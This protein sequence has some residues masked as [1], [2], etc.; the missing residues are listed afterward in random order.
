MT[1]TFFRTAI[2]A[3]TVGLV[4]QPGAQPEET[5]QIGPTAHA[6]LPANASELWLVPTGSS[7]EA[8]TTPTYRPLVDGVAK[9]QA[10][11]YAAALPLLTNPSLA[12]TPLYPYALYYT[13]LAQLRLDRVNDARRTLES[14][15]ERAP[16]GYV[17]VAATLAAGEAAS[18][19]GDH[20]EALRLY[21]RL[22]GEKAAVNDE[23]LTR[24]GRAAL[25][26]GDRRKA[27]EA[28]V[29]VYYEFP[30]TEAAIGASTQLESLQDQITR[31][32]YKG[33]LGRAQMLFGARRYAEAQS[34]FRALQRRAE[35]DDK[36]L[37]DLRVAECDFYLRR[38]AAARD[39]V[40]PY[41]EGAS[42]KAE[43]QF[44]HLSALREMGQHDQYT[45]ETRALVRDFPD[46]SWSE[47]ALNNLGTHYILTN[48]DQLAADTFREMFEKFPAGARAERAAWKYGWWTYK[49]G[50][51]QETVRVFESA[52]STFP[53]SDYRPSFLYWS[54]R[55]HAKLGAAAQARA[56]MRLV[57]TDYGNSYYG[58]LAEKR[59]SASRAGLSSPEDRVVHASREQVQA[60]ETPPL[61]TEPLVR[62]LLANGLYDDALNE[63]RYAQRAWGSSTAIDA[64]I[65]YA[66]YRKGELR[67]AI[68]LMR[69]AYPQHLTAGRQLPTELL[70]VIYPLT[71]WDS[72]R[73]HSAQHRLDPYIVAALIAQ[74]STFDPKIKSPANAWGLMQIVPATGRRLARSVGI[75]RFS[76]PMLTNAETNVRLGTL[77]FAN[78]VRQFGGTYYA[79]ASYN[80][81]EN[82]VV[83]WKAERPGIDE[84]EFIDDIPFP[85]TQNY[86]KR[87]LGTAEDYRMLYGEGGGKPLPV[88]GAPA[89]SRPSAKAPVKKSVK[90]PT[91]VRKSPPKKPAT[92]RRR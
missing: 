77:H 55:S 52:A 14:L 79:L 73:R 22:A 3:V 44:F 89:S 67:R 32:G 58:R 81:G 91:T 54:A 42:R 40:R 50:N 66:Y 5:G 85:E 65:A 86:V 45:A 10:G 7:R 31:T 84:D 26:A 28:F 53:R 76:T 39:G 63:L 72:I 29:R 80:A 87:I 34:A 62:L 56:R 35:G 1:S 90:K 75:R 25:A 27:A 17:S 12:K 69:R 15:R 9:V 13:G 38:W 60:P 8:R 70:Q 23:V 33:D 48:E 30:L 57:H 2:L 6:P 24:L 71:Y 49:N 4:P 37:V 18:T 43:A 78:L 88:A 92:T 61:R 46:S 51:Y 16:D 21:E 83:R 36:E 19:A 59:L 82:R 41:L 11:D 47:E 68:T 64:T 74:E 20:A